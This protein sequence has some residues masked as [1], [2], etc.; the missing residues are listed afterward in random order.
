MLEAIESDPIA[1]AGDP[2]IAQPDVLAETRNARAVA[3]PELG[4]LASLV[5]VFALSPYVALSTW[6]GIMFVQ[7]LTVLAAAC[8]LSVLAWQ[9]VRR[10]V[11]TT[12]HWIA[13]G[14]VVLGV[15]TL[16]FNYAAMV[17]RAAGVLT[18]A[19]DVEQMADITAE[20]TLDLWFSGVVIVVGAVSHGLFSLL[21]GEAR[22]K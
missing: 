20:L 19:T 5:S 21:N 1:A 18:P 2:P 9:L 12:A 6:S 11:G 10:R 14:L 3:D 17:L 13:R 7:R 8:A 4:E 16:A 15:G 22:V